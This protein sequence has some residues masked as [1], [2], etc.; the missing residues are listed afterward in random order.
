MVPRQSCAIGYACNAS[1]STL[2]ASQLSEITAS[3]TSWEIF[4]GTRIDEDFKWN[5]RAKMQTNEGK[6]EN[7][8]KN[9]E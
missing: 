1:T 4:A 9:L 2:A 6:V 7:K 8:K 5:K 3:P